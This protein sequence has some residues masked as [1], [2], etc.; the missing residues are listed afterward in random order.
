MDKKIWNCWD[1]K[2]VTRIW[3]RIRFTCNCTKIRSHHWMRVK[4]RKNSRSKKI[5]VI[6]IRTRDLNFYTLKLW[7]FLI[8][9][10]LKYNVT[11]LRAYKKVSSGSRS[12]PAWQLTSWYH[13]AVS[14][15]IWCLLA[16]NSSRVTRRVKNGYRKRAST[17]KII[18]FGSKNILK[19]GKG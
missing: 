14:W 11:R 12:E 8:F 16:L 13:L 2:W 1:F 15:R 7:F 6:G 3:W 19:C 17:L 4:K 10:P 9:T 5:S 18:W